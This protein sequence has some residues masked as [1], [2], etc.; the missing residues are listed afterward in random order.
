[1]LLAGVAALMV[2]LA[3]RAFHL[4]VLEREQ[5]RLAAQQQQARQRSLPAPRG[6]I[7]DRDGVP[8][9]ASEETFTISLAPRELRDRKQVQRLLQKHAGLTLAAAQRAVDARRSWV[10]LPGR[11]DAHT[12]QQ[13]H[14]QRGVYIER[15]LRR[16]YPRGPIAPELVGAVTADGRALSGLELEFNDALRGRE[17]RAVVRRAASGPIPGV[18][19]EMIEPAPGHDAGDCTRSSGACDPRNRRGQR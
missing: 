8:L 9:A 14:G 4:Q 1:L 5:W 2:L 3:G 10:V 16:F 15:V 19:Q 12:R 17:G 13:L 18:L 6:T 7:Y 11:F